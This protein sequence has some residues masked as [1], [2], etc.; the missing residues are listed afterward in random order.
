[1]RVDELDP[2][3]LERVIEFLHLHKYEDDDAHITLPVQTKAIQ[4]P[5][6]CATSGSK[7]DDDTSTLRNVAPQE[8][9]TDSLIDF[10]ADNQHIPMHKAFSDLE[11][12]SGESVAPFDDPNVSRAWNHVRIHRAAV[13]MEHGKLNGYAMKNFVALLDGLWR[14]T[15]FADFIRLTFDHL[16]HIDG[17]PAP[18]AALVGECTAHIMDLMSIADFKLRLRHDPILAFL[19]L[20]ALIEKTRASSD[21]RSSA[22]VCQQIRDTSSG[23][24]NDASDV[25]STITLTGP[26][27]SSPAAGTSVPTTPATS[28]DTSFSTP[29]NHISAT[30]HARIVSGLIYQKQQDAE[31]QEQIID[32]LSQQIA[33]LKAQAQ[34]LRDNDTTAIVRKGRGSFTMESGSVLQ[35]EAEMA[36][37]QKELADTKAELQDLEDVHDQLRRN[38]S[39]ARASSDDQELER[40]RKKNAQLQENL[41]VLTKEMREKITATVPE[42]FADIRAKEKA[43]DK[44]IGELRDELL[45]KSMLL[46]KHDDVVKENERLRNELAQK[47]PQTNGKTIEDQK[48]DWYYEKVALEKKLKEAEL[49]IDGLEKTKANGLSSPPVNVSAQASE[50][51][52]VSSPPAPVIMAEN[53]PPNSRPASNV[54]SNPGPISNSATGPKTFFERQKL[55][56]P[57]AGASI[58]NPPTA[59]LAMRPHVAPFTPQ[60]PAGSSNDPNIMFLQ[61][62]LHQSHQQ[63]ASLRKELMKGPAV[64]KKDEEIAQ[65]RR[66]NADRVRELAQLRKDLQRAEQ[67]NNNGPA[68][69]QG[70]N[71]PNNSSART[72]K[73]FGVG[74]Y[75]EALKSAGQDFIACTA[76]Y[77]PF[78][79]QFRGAPEDPK[80]GYLALRC[81]KCMAENMRWDV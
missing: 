22:L 40:E 34:K 20:Q 19:I 52:S 55:Q 29:D 11:T 76:C 28:R 47:K 79:G 70:L 60:A 69:G 49:R 62:A 72:I 42:E 21:D 18:C 46:A 43:K 33:E 74:A 81:K 50:Q 35:N 44:E 2:Y 3:T 48:A 41:Q 71:R 14:H 8:T 56:N 39:Q 59:P 80:A 13:I 53:I 37:L 45:Q 54:L 27:A 5:P 6:P 73:S 67:Q 12:L 36:S 61:N 38:T 66:T 75:N 57:Q 65:L 51:N 32:Q 15:S 31:K 63:L 10:A 1:V 25:S 9:P 16:K 4:G 24:I 58:P 23:D 30:E 78:N 77:A 7:A 17:I 64:T 26:V 68:I